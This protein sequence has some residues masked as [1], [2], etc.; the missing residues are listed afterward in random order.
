MLATVAELITDVRSLVNETVESFWTD[1]EITRWLNEGQEYIS[2]ATKV[3]SKYY[4]YTIETADLIDSREIRLPS[5]FITLDDGAVFYKGNAISEITLT[6]L[7]LYY[8][9]DWRDRT[10]TPIRFY[11]RAD[12]L[13]F[14]PKPT[15]GDAVK[16]YGVERAPTLV[17]AVVPFSGDYRCIPLRR[18]IRDYAIA[19]C[20]YKKRNRDDYRDKMN[21][22]E[23]GIVYIN[24]VVY[25][26]KNQPRRM[27]PAERNTGAYTSTDPLD[28]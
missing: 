10:G 27:I 4:D 11:R 8:G 6:E 25:G 7:N 18:Y 24:N 19:Q 14:F 13:G 20:W 9:Y 28:F 3:L 2:A 26:E 23:R 17:S 12:N 16:F 22:V 1:V 15:V 5:D 21:E